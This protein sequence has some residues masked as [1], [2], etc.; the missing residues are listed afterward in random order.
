M[1]S[2][3]RCLLSLT[4]L[5][6][7]L[8]CGEDDRKTGQENSSLVTYTEQ[9]EACAERNKYRNLY[10][11]DL[12]VHTRLSFDAY[13]YE[14]RTTPAQAYA[15]AKG[16]ELALPPLDA[17]G[18]G[19]RSVQLSRPLDFVAL[20]DHQEYLAE[21]H[22][23]TTPGTG[24]YDSALCRLYR[25]GGD[26]IVAIF[27]IRFTDPSPARFRDICQATGDECRETAME[28][29]RS[30]V[31]AA[32]DAYDGSSACSFTSFVGY[33]YS[34]TPRVANNHR[35]IIF[36]NAQVPEMPPSYFEKTTEEGLWAGLR[37]TCLDLEN[38]C[39][40]ISIPHNMNWSNGNMFVLDYRHLS[41]EEQA[42]VALLRETME[43]LA[44]V[45]QHKGDMECRNGF[46]GI[47]DDPL[48]NFEKIRDPDAVD[49]GDGPGMF[50]I[51]G[52]GCVSR[53]DFIRNILKLGLSEH[54]R[55]GINP[56]RLGVIGS[57][58]THN[59]TPGMTE[60]YEFHGHV[61]VAD[62][63]T[64]KR[65][66][67]MQVT[68]NTP[69]YNPGGLAAV[70][71][72]ENSR[73]ALFEA[74]RKREVY[75][76]SG[77][78]IRVRFFG[79]WDYSPELCEDPD[80]VSIGYARGVPMGGRLAKRPG[81]A[82]APVFAVM[83][84]QDP[85]VQDRPGTPLQRIQIV[86]GWIDGNGEEEEQVFEVAGDP[87]NGADGDRGSCDRLGEGWEKLCAVWT[88]PAFDLDL[89]AFY[90]ARVVENPTCSWRQ[91]DCSTYSPT[92]PDLPETCLDARFQKV[93]QERALTSPI[94]YDPAE[95]S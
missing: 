10:F 53:Y 70:W 94:W 58:D 25:G 15:F 64:D 35:N 2:R 44:E 85:G 55:L 39:D 56:Y 83:A 48:C 13:G 50:G 17:E 78:R 73:D 74:F 20:T 28:I 4:A 16:E 1:G 14:V 45:H 8:A 7:L 79:G 66:I 6:V 90:Y 51:A 75:S 29:W 26:M 46:D 60:E 11:G 88:D 69:A 34:G 24:A 81:E 95:A 33:E 22:L 76:T 86:K 91:M 93:I 84:M 41:P 12:H 18:N 59:G 57:T 68:H 54:R 87:N 61:G 3:I 62:D 36:R 21:V 40:V 27:G 65:L 31:Q 71:A 80:F 82:S 89:M 67:K 72:V 63:T 52:A 5:A 77:T 38:G 19:T 9:R 92:D 43:P 32:E 49:C 37:D 42:E 23:C 47:D 30:V